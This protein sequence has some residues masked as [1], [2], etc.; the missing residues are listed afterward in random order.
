[1][2]RSQLGCIVVAVLM[3]SGVALASPVYAHQRGQN[4]DKESGLEQ[5][6]SKRPPKTKAPEPLPQL[7]RDFAPP[8]PNRPWG[9]PKYLD[10]YRPRPHRYQRSRYGRP[11]Y[12]YY[13]DYTYRFGVP[14]SDDPYTDG[15]ERAYRQGVE[16][17]RNMERF[18]IQAERGLASYQQAMSAGHVA[19]AAGEFGPA[20]RH[21]LYAA[22]LNQGDPASRVCAAHAQIALGRYEPAAA[23]LRRA[24]ELQPKMVYLPMDIR[25]A[26]GD[27]TAFR[28]HL[29]ALR[30]AVESDRGNG[31]LWFLLGYCYYYSDDMTKA[32]EALATAAKLR[33]EDTLFAQLADLARMTVPRSEQGPAE[34]KPRP[35]GD[36]L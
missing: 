32:A 11:R 16:D 36:D 25:S 35:A 34:Q 4:E 33:P 12:Y 26:Y 28:N 23:L 14:F 1:M 5:P 15:I 31:D 2:C 13:D 7:K 21:F 9:R 20:A 27:R 22:T 19:F 18:E 3:V 8:D 24:F 17:G 10:P 6:S 29:D 30:M